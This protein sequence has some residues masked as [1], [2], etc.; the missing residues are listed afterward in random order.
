[1]WF[2]QL[3]EASH[4]LT[5]YLASLIFHK[6]V[7][8][9]S[10]EWEVNEETELGVTT[11]QEEKEN[12]EQTYN[13]ETQ[14][15]EQNLVKCWWEHL[16]YVSSMQYRWQI[17]PDREAGKR[18]SLSLPQLGEQNGLNHQELLVRYIVKC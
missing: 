16:S 17:D 6:S 18:L 7:R 1:M 9:R 14:E 4:S 11:S 10:V 8:W 5:E 12:N 15:T 3:A 2:E 13:K